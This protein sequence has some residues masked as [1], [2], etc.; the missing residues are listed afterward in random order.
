M[1]SEIIN[2]KP[3]LFNVLNTSKVNVK[4]CGCPIWSVN[5]ATSKQFEDAFVWDV[6]PYCV[7]LR[8]ISSWSTLLF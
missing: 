2:H 5:S 1:K 4:S 6:L 8:D 3:V 7:I